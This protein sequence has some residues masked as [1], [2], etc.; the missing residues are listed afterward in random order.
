VGEN[1]AQLMLRRRLV[2]LTSMMTNIFVKFAVLSFLVCAVSAKSSL[3]KSR[4]DCSKK[5]KILWP[6]YSDKKFYF[7]CI[8]EDSSVRRPCPSK[9][10]FNYYTQQCTWPEDWLQPPVLDNF[11]EPQETEFSPSCLISE[12]HLFWPDPSNHRDYFLCTG[13]GIYERLSCREGETFAFQM[14][15]CIEEPPTTAT[16]IPQERTPS[17]LEHELHLTWPDPWYPEYFF[18]C[19]GIGKFDMKRCPAGLVFVFMR[20][21]CEMSQTETQTTTTMTTTMGIQTV[22]MEDSTISYPVRKCLICW[23]PTCERFEMHYKWPDFDSKRNYFKCLSEGVL[24]LK[25]C[26]DDL[27]FDFHAQKCI[28]EKIK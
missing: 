26:K 15:M 20:Q 28:E 14:Q 27:L 4:V 24:T 11:I 1:L 7:E 6:D 18:I 9:T 17:C 25:T 23:R 16:L 13:I 3:S 21:M 8:S 19:T 5:N 2:K 22:P 10:V 12:L